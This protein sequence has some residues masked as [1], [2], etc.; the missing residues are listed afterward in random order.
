ME[1]R[2]DPTLPEL[3]YLPHALCQEEAL[4][5]STPLIFP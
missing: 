1:R 5:G 2:V 4:G 3:L